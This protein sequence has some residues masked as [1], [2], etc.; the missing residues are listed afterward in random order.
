MNS[1]LFK[2]L[3]CAVLTISA[4]TTSADIKGLFQKGAQVE[5]GDSI[6]G[7]MLKFA[8]DGVLHLVNAEAPALPT[9]CKIVLQENGAIWI[10]NLFPIHTEKDYHKWLKGEYIKEA[11]FT[12]PDTKKE[13]MRDIIVI[14][15][16]V[17]IDY[18]EWKEDDNKYTAKLTLN[19]I[20]KSPNA[21]DLFSGAIRYK[22]PD[23][24]Q[25]M[26]SYIKFIINED[27]SLQSI[28]LFGEEKTSCESYIN[29]Y[30]T[31]PYGVNL[32]KLPYQESSGY[33]SGVTYISN[34]KLTPIMPEENDN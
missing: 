31:C 2:I 6:Q 1:H 3:V 21:P 33:G 24:K 11:K 26:E 13:E 19:N 30:Y 18:K 34:L 15:P 10:E 9:E 32:N 5:I 16:F 27:M 12:N 20:V 23:E 29:Y 28:D 4:Q 22:H 14:Y 7:S 17:T 25:Q 8:T